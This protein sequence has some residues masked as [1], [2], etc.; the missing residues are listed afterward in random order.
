MNKDLRKELLKAIRT[1]NLDF[2]YSSCWMMSA[3]ELKA[4]LIEYVYAS[5]EENVSNE[6]IA[7]CVSHVIE[8]DC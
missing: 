8:E 2:F 1:A 5:G 4:I 7:R 6:A 3:D